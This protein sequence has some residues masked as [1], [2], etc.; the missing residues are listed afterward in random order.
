MNN[1]PFPCY[2]RS[3]R[4]QI[5]SDAHICPHCSAS[6]HVRQSPATAGSWSLFRV[7]RDL[8]IRY[9]VY[10]A[11]TLVTLFLFVLSARLAP[12]AAVLWGPSSVAAVL[13]RLSPWIPLIVLETYWLHWLVSNW[14]SLRPRRPS[15]RS[16]LAAGGVGVVLACLPVIRNTPV[17]HTLYARASVLI[18]VPIVLCL[19]A[20]FAMSVRRLY[21][22]DRTNAP[23]GVPYSLVGLLLGFA[24]SGAYKPDA[25][26]PALGVVGLVCAAVGASKRSRLGW[27][28]IAAAFILVIGGRLLW[29][30]AWLVITRYLPL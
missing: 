15:R 10:V 16:F 20:L 29:P 21:L 22:D 1:D 27:L 12:E 30:M 18:V 28:A 3:C 13:L 14:R 2:C 25:V 5:P 19:L 7:A 23:E 26:A 4:Q 17:G 6:Q 8:A 9:P 11:A 24:S